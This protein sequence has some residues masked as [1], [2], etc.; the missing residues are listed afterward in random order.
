MCADTRQSGRS[1][2]VSDATDAG[3]S[4]PRRAGAGIGRGRWCSASWIVCPSA[5]G[6]PVCKSPCS[7]RS[8]RSTTLES[9]FPDIDRIDLLQSTL[10]FE[11][12]D[13][14][15]FRHALVHEAVYALLGSEDA[16]R[17]HA[18]AAAHF[19]AI[20]P[21]DYAYH[22]LRSG[23]ARMAVEACAA[24]SEWLLGDNRHQHA[25]RI[26]ERGLQLEP[27]GEVR[28]RLLLSKAQVLRERGE[29]AA[30]IAASRQAHDSTADAGLR[31][32]ALVLAA[33]LLKRH[34][35]L[36]RA[37]AP[38]APS[39][40]DRRAAKRTRSRPRRTRARMGQQHVHCAGNRIA[41]VGTI[42]RA[43]PTGRASRRRSHEGCR[44]RRPRRRL[45]RQR[46]GA[47]GTPLLLAMRTTCG[48]RGSK[49][50]CRCLPRN[51]G[52]HGEHARTGS[53]RAWTS[54]SKPSIKP[55]AGRPR[56]MKC[57]PVLLSPKC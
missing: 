13:R 42:W 48:F 2:A 29:L 17:L 40:A 8:F 41:A 19:R 5:R 54:C 25:E 7:G 18:Q 15:C 38:A 51:D 47:I 52:I 37:A 33:T 53:G 50:D 30:A 32:Q 16:A 57:S 26:V 14:L 56:S 20:N 35:Q 43:R 4:R 31:V 27:E 1:P 9:L 6:W 24:A 39:V 45:L 34:N 49:S 36:Q 23:D 12:G 11:Q 21:G 3:R 55:G 44:A 22:A 10:I 28:A 46:Q